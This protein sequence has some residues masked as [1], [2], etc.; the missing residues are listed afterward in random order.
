MSNRVISKEYESAKEIL[1]FTDYVA[2]PVTIDA[3]DVPEV[4]GKKIMKAG[5][6]IG[7]KSGTILLEGKKAESKLADAEPAYLV[8]GDEDNNKIKWIAVMPG[9]VGHSIKIKI[10]AGGTEDTTVEVGKDSNF[11]VITVKAK[12]TDPSTIIATAAEVK[13]KVE[14]HADAKKMV[15]CELVGDGSVAVVAVSATALDGGADATVANAEG[16]LLKDVDVTNG[17]REG[18]M[19]IW[20][21]VDV[22][23][24]D[25]SIPI[26]GDNGLVKQLPKITF[27]K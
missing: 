26:S 15:T 6:P 4:V 19:L 24:I 18:A 11:D 8:T 21:F 20:G 10:E 3:T 5:T 13:A 22:S 7:G 1:K 27:L 25:Q 17:D 16:I 2:M 9:T 14:A 23:K 12:K